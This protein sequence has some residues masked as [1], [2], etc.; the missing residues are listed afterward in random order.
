M[1]VIDGDGSSPHTRGL[2]P[3][4]VGA[5]AVGGIIPAHAG[6]T[7]WPCGAPRTSWDHPRTRGVYSRGVPW[8]RRWL[9]SSPHTR[10]LLERKA[11]RARS[12]GIIPAHAGFTPCRRRSHRPGPDHP[13]TRGV[14]DRFSIG[15]LPVA[16]SSPH[17][18]GLHPAAGGQLPGHGIIPAHAGFT[19]GRPRVSS[20]RADHPRTR[21]V[22]AMKNLTGGVIGGSSPHTRGLRGE[23]PRPVRRPGISPAHA[24]FTRGW[25]GRRTPSTDHPRTRGVYR[26]RS[27]MLERERGSSPHTRG[28]HLFSK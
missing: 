10:G 20:P 26:W 15:F 23:G 27:R 19:A 2:L 13:R 5:V 6:F 11:S 7:S 18:R 21:G 3:D 25:A 8:R 16:G 17:T 4:V 9:G 28:L 14:Y 1:A 24:G 22:Y 12:N